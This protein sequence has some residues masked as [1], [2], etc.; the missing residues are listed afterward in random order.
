MNVLNGVLVDSF[1]RGVQCI[2]NSFRPTMDLMKGGTINDIY[3]IFCI[4]SEETEYA[5]HIEFS[6]YRALSLC[7]IVADSTISPHDTKGRI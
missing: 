5:P 1:R 2:I 3:P 6:L 4:P 7:L